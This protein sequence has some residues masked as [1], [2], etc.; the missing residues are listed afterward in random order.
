M[1]DTTALEKTISDAE[2][3]GA[4]VG[5]AIRDGGG[6]S[7]SHN[8]DERF[9]SASTV[10][11]PIMIEI[12]RQIDA[13]QRSLEDL[14]VVTSE[15]HSFGSGVLHD[16]HAGLE[17][18]LGDLLYLMMSISDNTAT[19]ILIDMAGMDRV[20]AL[21]QELG[22][23]GS[24]LGRKMQGKRAEGSQSENWATANDYTALV[25]K[26]LAGEVAAPESCEKMVGILRQQQNTRRVGRFVPETDGVEWG[27]KT[28]SIAGVVNDVGFV[29]SD[30]GS[31]VVSV[32]LHDMP[33]MVTGERVIGEIARHA[34][35]LSGVA[36]PLRTS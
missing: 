28:G 9:R 19:N 20:N 15:D 35:E 17:V 12:F 25:T 2:A 10:K 36:E 4:T 7:F 6:W 32:F 11:I 33:D 13:G 22:M 31:V 21:M 26:L 8:G 24:S 14:Y 5:V 34:M 16:M 27:S 18:T 30:A 29:R 1:P 3:L 23:T